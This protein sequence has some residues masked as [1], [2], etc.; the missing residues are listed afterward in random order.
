MI[1]ILQGDCRTVLA[2]LAPASVHCV[3]TSPPYFGLRDYGVDGQIGLERTPEQY[4]RE[5]V[6]VMRGVRRVLREDGTCWL[7]IGDSYNAAGRIGHGTRIGY[8]QGTNRASRDGEDH[9]RARRQPQA[10]RP[11]D[12][13]VAR[14]AGAAGG[15]LVAAQRHH[16]EQA[17]LHARERHRPA[18]QRPR[19][20]VPADQGGPLL[21][22]RG[23]HRRANISE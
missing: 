2:R 5:I 14:G 3:I 4:V 12:D 1:H 19:A 13:P 23:G 9:A 6:H 20:R 15:R 16:L 10:Q 11:A 8:K 7:N 18:D 17:V 22:R 21:L